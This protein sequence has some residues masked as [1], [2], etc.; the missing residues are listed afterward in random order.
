VLNIPQ[1]SGQLLE[2]CCSGKITLLVCGYNCEVWKKRKGRLKSE[3][4]ARRLIIIQN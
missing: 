1:G 2:K 4:L 3:Q